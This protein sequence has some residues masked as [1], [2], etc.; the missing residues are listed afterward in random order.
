ML[1]LSRYFQLVRQLPD[2]AR[3]NGVHLVLLRL[4][5]ASNLSLGAIE[6]NPFQLRC[7]DIHSGVTTGGFNGT[8]AQGWGLLSIEIY[9]IKVRLQ[10]D[11]RP[12]LILYI[13]NS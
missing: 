11:D 7:R 1:I 5:I 9:D 13:D 8:L 12:Y 2:S 6:S 10:V 4:H 3:T